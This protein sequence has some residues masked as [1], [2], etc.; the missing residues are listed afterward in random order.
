[1]APRIRYTH[2][3]W[4]LA[5]LAALALGA[6]SA[7][8]AAGTS[9][10][11][12]ATRRAAA[13]PL[14]ADR[15]VN[16]QVVTLGADGREVERRREL[17]RVYVEYLG[18]G[19]EIELV[20][21]PGGAFS[22]G[23]VDDE[24]RL[25]VASFERM[26]ESASDSRERASAE[27]PRRRVRV[28]AFHI[29]R[30]EVT[31]AQWRAVAALPRAVRHLDASPSEFRGDDRPVESVSWH[32]AMEF[33]ARLSRATGRVYTLPTEAEW[34]YACRAGT[35]APF[36]FGPTLSAVFANYWADSAFGE[37]AA[38]DCREETVPVGSLGVANAFGLYDMH[39][40]VAEWCLDPWHASYRG[41]PLDGRAWD[42]RGDPRHRV[43]R[44]G[45]WYDH[46]V[47][48][49]SASRIE[50]DDGETDDDTGFRVVLRRR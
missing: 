24:L 21:V 3:Q 23:A 37:G 28:D 9:G 2:A 17:G 35:S 40:N 49:R 31:Q 12:S 50:Q 1:M 14:P 39:G 6:A 7:G 43:T 8:A 30:F 44:G 5:V 18:G 34:E 41:A 33:C 36:H 42:A 45:S 11:D 25:A 29:A 22:M 10:Q 4:R 27:T 26:G 19:V 13:G 32:D 47:N 20:E 16:F 15:Q 48:C 38:G 46:P